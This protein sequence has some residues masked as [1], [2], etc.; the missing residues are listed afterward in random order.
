MR[1]SK[2]RRNL[3]R[4][5]LPKLKQLPP[6][7]SAFAVRLVRDAVCVRIEKNYQLDERERQHLR[8]KKS[9]KANPELEH[10]QLKKLRKNR[11][12]SQAIMAIS[13]Q[14]A[15]KLKKCLNLFSQ[16]QGLILIRLNILRSL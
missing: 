11:L 7:K 4:N 15:R 9:E 8:I 10:Q 1:S 2:T 13:T 3:D 14:F 6:V 5:I 12:K 16:R